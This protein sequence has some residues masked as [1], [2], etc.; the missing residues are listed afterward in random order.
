MI[1][2]KAKKL[3]DVVFP[4]KYR[5]DGI[6]KTHFGLTKREYFAGIIMSRLAEYDIMSEK[7]SLK[8]HCNAIAK[9]SCLYADSLLEELSK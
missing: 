7:Q 1:T 8:E 3:P 6:T 2:E 9:L 5:I 4:Q